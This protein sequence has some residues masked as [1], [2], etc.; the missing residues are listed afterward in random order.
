[1]HEREVARQFPEAADKLWRKQQCCITSS[2][3]DSQLPQPLPESPL[4]LPI[5]VSLENSRHRL[6]L[7]HRTVRPLSRDMANA[8][9]GAARSNRNPLALAR[10]P[11]TQCA[12][13]TGKPVQHQTNG[14]RMLQSENEAKFKFCPLLKTHDDK[15]KCCQGASCMMWRWSPGKEKGYCG[16]AGKPASAA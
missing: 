6:A 9:E 14:E 4:F 7:I 12:I 2:S 15:M 8:H 11:G 16:L 10:P 1:M 3:R 5:D 13:P